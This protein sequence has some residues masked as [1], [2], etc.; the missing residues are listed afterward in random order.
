MSVSVFTWFYN[1]NISDKE[2][3]LHAGTVRL[4][5]TND[6]FSY[7]KQLESIHYFQYA[8]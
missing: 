2:F 8:L 4:S 1:T 7:A 5:V 3:L 6:S